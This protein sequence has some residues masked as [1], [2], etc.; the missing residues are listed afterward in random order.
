[1]NYPEHR[2]KPA[3]TTVISMT[4]HHRGAPDFNVAQR[5]AASAFDP[6]SSARQ[7]VRRSS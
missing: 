6:I 7:L 1:M 3:T 5:H 2:T 4:R